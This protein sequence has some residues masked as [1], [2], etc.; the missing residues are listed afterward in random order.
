LE[1]RVTSGIVRVELPR[2]I[3]PVSLEVGGRI[4]L[5]STDAG[6]DV[7]GPVA[8]RSASEIIFRIP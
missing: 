6:L 3:V 8:E 1:A 7:P 5:R 2:G 4:Y